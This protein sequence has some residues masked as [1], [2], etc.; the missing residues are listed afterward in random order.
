MEAE[1]RCSD[2]AKLLDRGKIVVTKL[3][4]SIGY[5]YKLIIIKQFIDIKRFIF[6]LVNSIISSVFQVK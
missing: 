2:L 3:S 6:S 1:G 5:S 4:T